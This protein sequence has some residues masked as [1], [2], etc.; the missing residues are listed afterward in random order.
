MFSAAGAN[1][2]CRGSYDGSFL[3]IMRPDDAQL[4]GCMK[5]IDDGNEIK[6]ICY[7]S[8]PT[9]RFWENLADRK[10]EVLTGIAVIGVAILT[11]ATTGAVLVGSI[12]GIA[13]LCGLSDY[14]QDLMLYVLLTYL[15]G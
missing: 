11:I 5:Y 1:S 9:I 13:G 3:E 6:A 7:R 12:I 2:T 14:S 4:V 8:S 10:W 15:I